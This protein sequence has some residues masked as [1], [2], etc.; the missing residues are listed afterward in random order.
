MKVTTAAPFADVAIGYA[1]RFPEV[2]SSASLTTAEVE[3]NRLIEEYLPYVRTI[4]AKVR[5]SL[6]AHV[7]ADDLYSAGVTGLIAAADRYNPGKAVTFGGYVCLRIRCAMIDELRRLD[8]NTRRSRI[9]SKE[10][11]AAV[12]QTEQVLGRAPTDEELSAHLKI[13][14]AELARRRETAK[15]VRIISL[16]GEPESGASGV[17]PLHEAIA[18][19]NQECV[20][21]VMEKE[22]LK[23]HLVNRMAELPDVQKKVLALYYFEGLRFAEI[24]EVFDLTESRI[25]QIHRQAVTKLRTAVGLWNG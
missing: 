23:Q 5:R 19:N 2:A 9:R 8:S 13:S 6:P 12:Q 21:E 14:V 18:D 25:S 10:L 7:D 4:L 3:R 15:P 16:D 17:Q 24:A 22:E 1:P 11:Q 20:R